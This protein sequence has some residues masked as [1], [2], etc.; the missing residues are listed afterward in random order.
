MLPSKSARQTTDYMI[1]IILTIAIYHARM[2]YVSYGKPMQLSN[3]K[4]G[5]L[6]LSNPLHQLF[7]SNDL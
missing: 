7:L 5:A 2:A 3:N 1:L 4:L 6:R